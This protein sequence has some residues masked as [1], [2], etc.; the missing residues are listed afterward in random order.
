MGVLAET[1]YPGL[2]LYVLILAMAFRNTRRVQRLPRETTGQGEIAAYGAALEA[3]FVVYFVGGTFL[4]HQYNEMAWH[5]V[6]LSLVLL[7]V[8][9]RAAE[10][11]EPAPDDESLGWSE[12]AAAAIRSA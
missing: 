8:A 9:R 12:G 10:E 5:W 2:L 1:G 7:N 4:P 11:P 6:A 3:A